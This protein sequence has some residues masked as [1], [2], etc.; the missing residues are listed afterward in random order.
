[1]NE[2]LR[3]ANGASSVTG[4]E[5]KGLTIAQIEGLMGM[6]RN[7]QMDESGL[8]VLEQIFEQLSFALLGILL[9]TASSCVNEGYDHLDARSS[10]GA[11]LVLK[12]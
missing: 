8:Q 12:G 11:G 10:Q 7:H 3:P 9:A 2:Q 4:L 5:D 6:T 1:M